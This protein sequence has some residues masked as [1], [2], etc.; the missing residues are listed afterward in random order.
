MHRIC[1]SAFI[2]VVQN[3]TLSDSKHSERICEDLIVFTHPA[4]H[5]FLHRG[6]TNLK[7]SFTLISFA[8]DLFA[9]L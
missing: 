4:C 1:Y 7:L 5:P 9:L 8:L 6:S 3:V 2:H